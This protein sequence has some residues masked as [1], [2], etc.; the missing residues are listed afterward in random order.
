MQGEARHAELLWGIGAQED[1]HASV[2]RRRR[3][4]VARSGLLAQGNQE[5][6]LGTMRTRQE[7]YELIDY[8]A[9]TAKDQEWS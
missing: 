1:R 9:F 7:L 6:M 3:G 4:G 8:P 2:V 5:G